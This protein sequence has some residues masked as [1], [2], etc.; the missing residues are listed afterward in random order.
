MGITRKSFKAR[1][2]G[3]LLA[4]VAGA[5]ALAGPASAIPAGSGAGAAPKSGALATEPGNVFTTA[6]DIYLVLIVAGVAIACAALGFAVFAHM[7]GQRTAST[8]A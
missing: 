6:G 3:V 8:K 5:L 7:R 1:F 4:V 2:A